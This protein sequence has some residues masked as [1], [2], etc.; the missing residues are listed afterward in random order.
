MAQSRPTPARFGPALMG[1]TAK[2]SANDPTLFGKPTSSAAG[3]AGGGTVPHPDG[4]AAPKQMSPSNAGY[5]TPDQG[6]FECDNCQHF[7]AP[8]SCEWVSG[9]I[10]PKGCCN[11]FEQGTPQGGQ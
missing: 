3:P 7:Q 9:A 4:S 2:P 11:N 5:Q 6:P 8:G 1:L 10:D